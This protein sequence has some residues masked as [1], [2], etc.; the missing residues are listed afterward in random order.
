VSAK[1]SEAVW[2]KVGATLA[3]K[4]VK[5][6]QFALLSAASISSDKYR[7]YCFVAT[8]LFREISK[9]PQSEAATIM[10]GILAGK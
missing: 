8:M 7:D 3:G 6:E 9:L 5:N 2:K 4:G 10:R 1:V